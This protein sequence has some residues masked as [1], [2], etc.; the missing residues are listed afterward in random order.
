MALLH[1]G[2]Q[3]TI[4]RMEEAWAIGWGWVVVWFCISLDSEGAWTMLLQEAFLHGI[5][6]GILMGWRCSLVPGVHAASG[7]SGHPGGA[8]VPGHLRLPGQQ[9]GADAEL[10]LPCPS[11]CHRAQTCARLLFGGGFRRVK[12][13]H[14]IECQTEA[15]PSSQVADLSRAHE[16]MA[17][18]ANVLVLEVV[19]AMLSWGGHNYAQAVAGKPKNA[20]RWCRLFFVLLPECEV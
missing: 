13:G 3:G 20:C 10:P 8:P 1:L 2:S 19:D 4:N 12:G 7:A 6:E 14:Q 16:V 11:A 5:R 17:L 15:V 18:N 9:D